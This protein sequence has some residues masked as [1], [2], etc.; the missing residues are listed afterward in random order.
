MLGVCRRLGSVAGTV[1][2]LVLVSVPVQAQEIQWRLDYNAA[3]KEA[4]EKNRPLFLDVYI[5][6]CLY[7]TK[8]DN[9]TFRDAALVKALNDHF[10]PVKVD[11][12]RNPILLQG[13][14]ILEFPTMAFLGADNS[15]LSQQKG[16]VEAPI[17]LQQVQKVMASLKPAP[18]QVATQSQTVTQTKK[19]TSNPIPNVTQVQYPE[20]K[21]P[22]PPPFY[23][24]ARI[25]PGWENRGGVWPGPRDWL[26]RNQAVAQ[27]FQ[28]VEERVFRAR[29]LLSQAQDDY[30]RQ[31]W[32]SCMEHCKTLNALYPDLQEGVEA[33]QLVFRIQNNP[34]LLDRLARDLTEN[35]AEI[36]WELAQS[37][38]RQ[39]LGSQAVPYLE[40]IV[41]SC[42]GTRFAAAAQEYLTRLAVNQPLSK[43]TMGG[44]VGFYNP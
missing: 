13:Q 3:F 19:P 33:R 2:A 12:E 24:D 23:A 34:E 9:S 29:Q 8:L 39:N 25:G 7:C 38:F 30:R 20:Q 43:N 11:Y 42:P 27:P 40:K 21:K 36:Y 16:F 1:L 5:P 6:N 18:A 41:Q 10:I 37:K 17:L 35:L 31:Q 15:A 28:P 32:V 22:V 14:S 4:A 26:T 44:K